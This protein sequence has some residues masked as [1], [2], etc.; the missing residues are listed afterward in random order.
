M[1]ITI[2]LTGV[3]VYIIVWAVVP[4]V[5]TILIRRKD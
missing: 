5:V 3:L 2:V 1:N 4:Y